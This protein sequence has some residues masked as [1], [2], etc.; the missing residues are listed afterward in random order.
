MVQQVILINMLPKQIKDLADNF[1]RAFDLEHSPE[2]AFRDAHN[3]T[4][5]FMVQNGLGWSG[6]AMGKF[7]KYATEYLEQRA[8]FVREKLEQ[9]ITATGIEPYSELA[10]D[11]KTQFASYLNPAVR[12]A[13]SYFEML[14][15]TTEAPPGFTDQ[16]R[17]GFTTII[18]RTNAELEFFCASLPARHKNQNQ[19]ASVTIGKLTGISGNVTNS[20]ITVNDFSS[21]PYSLRKPSE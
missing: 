3:K 19:S 6:F 21:T 10:S 2:K 16:A 15:K 17:T 5:A 20:H 9:V 4:A 1:V 14:R 13:E 12:G 18:T 8:S 7:A 11:L